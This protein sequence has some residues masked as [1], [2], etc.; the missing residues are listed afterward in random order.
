MSH[1]SLAL[2][3]LL[4]GSDLVVVAECYSALTARLVEDQGFAAAYIGGNAMGAMHDAIPDHGLMTTTEMIEHAAR[5]ASRISI[6]L[7]VD[8]DQGGETAVNVRRTVRSFEQAGAAAIHLEDTVNPKHLFTGVDQL[9]PIDTMRSR[10]EAAVG[11]RTDDHFVIIA[12]SDERFNGGT[13]DETV[14]RGVAY[15][16][17]GADV[18]MVVHLG[19]ADDIATVASAVPIPLLDINQPI[20]KARSGGLKV[21]VFTGTSVPTALRAH[22]GWLQEILTTGELDS[23]SRGTD[24]VE[25][26]RLL[27]DDSYLEVAAHWPR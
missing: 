20:D 26:A 12:R 2:R 10:L 27:D 3:E 24:P 6:P 9:V 1:Q 11:A 4:R 7:I 22:R 17:S 13:L 8:A 23:E 15:A 19:S 25:Y 16:D 5:I 14:R 18:F 21:D